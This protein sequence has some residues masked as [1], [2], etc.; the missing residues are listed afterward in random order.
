VFDT[1]EQARAAAPPEGVDAPGVA[2]ASLQF[3][4]VIA[5]A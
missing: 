3:G 1:E 2:M 4:E 5:S